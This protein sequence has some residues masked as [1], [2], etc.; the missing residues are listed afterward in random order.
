M[1]REKA[2]PWVRPLI[3]VGFIL[4]ACGGE[5]GTVDTSGALAQSGALGGLAAAEEI[6]SDTETYEAVTPERM[7]DT[8]TAE[9]AGITFVAGDSTDPRTVSIEAVSPTEFRSAARD[10]SGACWGARDVATDNGT[11][12][13]RERLE[14]CTADAFSPSAYSLDGW[15]P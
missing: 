14:T 9:D 7:N 10:D 3:A 13:A 1:E 4:A 2:S 8:Q 11:E 6:Y 12:F 15:A 5:S